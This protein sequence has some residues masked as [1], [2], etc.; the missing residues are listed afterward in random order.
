MKIGI[1]KLFK[2]ENILCP[3]KWLFIMRSFR[4][5]AVAGWIKLKKCN[6]TWFQKQEIFHSRSLFPK[7]F[8]SVLSHRKKKLK[9]FPSTVQHFSSKKGNCWRFYR[10]LRTIHNRKP[11]QWRLPIFTHVWNFLYSRF[12]TFQRDFFSCFMLRAE[13]EKARNYE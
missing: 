4:A 13:N 2:V 8:S 12:L 6:F 11:A 3:L 7:S 5:S 1:L 10:N 9:R